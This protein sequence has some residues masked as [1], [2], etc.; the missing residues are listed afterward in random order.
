MIHR[1]L[2]T[3]PKAN[4]GLARRCLQPS[5]DEGPQPEGQW[6]IAMSTGRR[7]G[8]ISGKQRLLL[9]PPIPEGSPASARI[10][11]GSV[12]VGE[13]CGELAGHQRG[14]GSASSPPE[15][16][17]RGTECCGVVQADKSH[18]A[19]GVAAVS[20][21]AARRWGFHGLWSCDGADAFG[22]CT[23]LVTAR[24]VTRSWP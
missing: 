11:G 15:G 18:E 4:H 9:L 16:S 21:G 22:P 1:G 13:G 19:K 8:E 24:V 3:P 14:W 10:P 2:R 12:V 20:L 6:R 7:W 5:N 23:Y 17:K